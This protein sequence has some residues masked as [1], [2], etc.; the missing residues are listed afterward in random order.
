MK[1]TLISL[2]LFLTSLVYLPSLSAND[3]QLPDSDYGYSDGEDEDGE[4]DEN[5]EN[6]EN[7]GDSY[8]HI[9]GG[10]DN[11]TDSYDVYRRSPDNNN[12]GDYDVYRRGSNSDEEDG[13][14]SAP[15]K[16][17]LL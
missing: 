4:D 11:S 12:T 9:Y 8:H 16:G 5:D 17:W 10:P 15:S 6:D 2:V 3:W 13:N 14:Y 1:N 7:D